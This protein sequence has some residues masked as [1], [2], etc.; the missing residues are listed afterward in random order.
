MQTN[1]SCPCCG[2]ALLRHAKGN[3]LY[4]FCTSCWQE[5]PA[6]ALA[7]ILPP[8][9]LLTTVVSQDVQPETVP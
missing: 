2:A 7:N 5:M 8:D 4:W 6:S 9:S 3:S 1:F